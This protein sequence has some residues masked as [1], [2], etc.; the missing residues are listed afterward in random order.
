MNRPPAAD[1]VL[2]DV[3]AVEDELAPALVADEL[4]ADVVPGAV[5][6][7]LRPALAVAVAPEAV[8]RAWRWWWRCRRWAPW[9]VAVP[10]RPVSV[11]HQDAGAVPTS[12]AVLVGVVEI[13]VTDS[14]M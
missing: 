11:D 14:R 2:A 12:A 5:V 8:C 3:G 7:E 1:A 10:E 13:A 6:A 9:S 4:V